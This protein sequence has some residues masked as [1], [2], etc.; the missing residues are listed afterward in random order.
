MWY[1]PATTAESLEEV[2]GDIRGQGVD[3]KE[4]INFDMWQLQ[5]ALPRDDE[6]YVLATSGGSL[7]KVPN[8]RTA[9]RMASDMNIPTELV[10]E[11]LNYLDFPSMMKCRTVRNI[12][13]H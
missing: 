1:Y 2:L 9:I 7:G 4:E 3:G 8:C 13:D 6:R 5:V 12:P 11:I 10:A